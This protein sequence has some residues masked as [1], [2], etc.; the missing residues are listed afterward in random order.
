M[1]R[2]ICSLVLIFLAGTVLAQPGKVP[3]KQVEGKTYYVHKVKRGNTLYG[4][5]KTYAVPV[6]D[7]LSANPGAKDGLKVGQEVLIPKIGDGLQLEGNNGQVTPTNQDKYYPH[8]VQGGET[9]YSIARTYGLKGKKLVKINGERALAIGDTIF[10]PKSAVDIAQ[11]T[12][13]E[14]IP[15]I[16][17]PVHP[18]ADPGDSIVMHTVAAGE[19]LYGLAQKY[20][21]TQEKIKKLN[22]GLPQGLKVGQE[23]RVPIK[24]L[25][26]FDE[27]TDSIKEGVA[28]TLQDTRKV[29]T[30]SNY[31]VGVFLPFKLDAYDAHMAKCPTFGNCKPYLQ[32]VKAVEFY[33]GVEMAVDSLRKA[34][35]SVNIRVYDTKGDTSTMRKLL[36]K[37]E[38]KALDLMFGPIIPLNQKMAANFAKEQIIRMIS[39]VT[40][41]NKILFKNPYVTK[42]I[43]S[44]PTQV[45]AIAH[46]IAKKHGDANVILIND[47][48][49]KDHQYLSKVF[50][51][52]YRSEIANRPDRMRDSAYVTTKGY[53]LGNVGNVL[54][55]DALNILVVP[56]K[57]IAFVSSF[58]TD[59]NRLKNSRGM[60]NT[61]FM[62]FGL[63]DWAKY[64]Q[65]DYDRVSKYNVHIPSSGYID[66][67]AQ[68][69]VDFTRKYRAKYN[70]DPSKLTFVGFD[71]M[72]HQLGGM[73]LMGV[74]DAT[75]L[76]YLQLDHLQMNFNYEQVG[77]NNGFENRNVYILAYQDY[78]LIRQK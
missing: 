13:D 43:A 61:G 57:D 71:I 4:L 7:I 22:L 50:Q 26:P 15:A 23:I 10:I 53:K 54:K 9:L 1:Q 77:D 62:V 41:S 35:L 59:L 37:E 25:R 64:H 44:T 2:I 20:Q 63:E 12:N 76:N 49:R 40:S 28:D 39:P 69:I 47:N 8:V 52:A 78:R 56:S 38:V 74:G 11:N 42:T 24:V 46:Y 58:L 67:N 34:G 72:M 33:N 27:L 21:T 30:K 55:T 45:K 16:K 32:T 5:H 75:R 73:M 65:L 36:Q 60:R 6:E 3:E 14:V 48:S 68:K 51:K 70:N 31:E 66:Y 18:L 17:H 19:T 29:V